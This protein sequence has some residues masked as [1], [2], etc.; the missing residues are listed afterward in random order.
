MRNIE[1]SKKPISYL[2]KDFDDFRRALIEYAKTYFPNS[3]NDFSESS[4]GSL[5]LEMAA[6]VG[7]TLSF[8]TDKQAQESFLSTAL[9]RKAIIGHAR[10]H[11]Y[12]VHGKIPSQVKLDFY[13]V[14]PA[15]DLEDDTNVPDYRYAMHISKAIV[16]APKFGQDFST[17]GIINFGQNSTTD[18]LTIEVYKVDNATQKPTFYLLKKSI[19]A[20]AGR[21]KTQRFTFT[22]PKPYDK[23]KLEDSEGII[24]VVSITDSD[25]LNWWEVPHLAQ[26]LVEES[27]LNVPQNDPDLSVFSETT[28]YLLKLRRRTRRFVT[29]H[30]TDGTLDIQFGSGTSTLG[31]LEITPNPE[32]VGLA[33]PGFQRQFDYPTDPTNFLRTGV[34]GL[35]PSNTTLVVTY[36]V[37]GGEKSNVP[38][39]EITEIR[40]IESRF[41]DTTGLDAVLLQS[42]RNSVIVNNTEPAR[43]G[44]EEED[45]EE[46]RLNAMA[47][48]SAQMRAVNAQD[49]IVLS[50]QMPPKYGSIF[51][52]TIVQDFQ[53][54]Q[55]EGK[56]PNPLALNLY[57]LGQDNEGR[58]ATV[59]RAIKENLRQHL[60]L[61]RIL[62]D[63]INIKDAYIINIGLAYE[64]VVSKEANGSEVLLNC[65]KKLKELF[66]IKKWSISQPIILSQIYAELDRIKGV[67]TVVKVQIVNLWK[68][69]QYGGTVY[70]I[71]G[72]TKDGVIYPSINPS[73]FEIK[74]SDTDIVGRVIV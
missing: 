7:D 63:A 4:I 36:R 44:K 52:A 66:D 34:Y 6:A 60:R 55:T 13:Q 25:G 17:T 73:I 32:S 67:Q 65:H 10:D 14:I 40:S 26:E 68:E 8:Y 62:T 57:V 37:G 51:K 50:Y 28:P 11:G 41:V 24:D 23:I 43:G 30:N 18:P 5:F 58:L 47:L 45:I 38:P 15:I 46:I 29:H 56:L 42:V 53:Y 49:Y 27:V 71:Q 35:A 33:I 48:F 22:D 1:E 19:N 64:I 70:D 39:N 31:D 12:K 20:V 21:T 74:Y 16:S 61:R 3:Y 59:N 9:T 69:P 2:N 72:A 54:T